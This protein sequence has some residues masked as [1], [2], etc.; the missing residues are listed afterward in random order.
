LLLQRFFVKARCAEHERLKHLCLSR[1]V[2]LLGLS[3]Q[4]VDELRPL[5]EHG[6]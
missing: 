3:Q 6:V 5:F 4:N 2:R 1:C